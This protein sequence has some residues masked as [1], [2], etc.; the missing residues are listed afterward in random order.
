MACLE[1]TPSRVHVFER[2]ATLLGCSEVSL[3]VAMS[4]LI[5]IVRSV[6]ELS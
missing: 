2:G 1:Y 6:R 5:A 4:Y 3:A